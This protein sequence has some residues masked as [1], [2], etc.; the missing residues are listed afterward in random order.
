MVLDELSRYRSRVLCSTAEPPTLCAKANI[1]PKAPRSTPGDALPLSSSMISVPSES[2][3][4]SSV[5]SFAN[6]RREGIASIAAS[7]PCT[8]RDAQAAPA[9]KLWPAEKKNSPSK[10]AVAAIA[11]ASA[12]ILS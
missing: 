11:S 2:S 6:P 8:S 1:S 3:A 7:V 10:T 12:D 9:Q 4:P 5:V